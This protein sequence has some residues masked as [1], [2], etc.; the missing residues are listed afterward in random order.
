[1]PACRDDCRWELEL[2][3]VWGFVEPLLFWTSRPPLRA[4]R[5]D[6]ERRVIAAVTGSSSAG[7]WFWDAWTC[8]CGVDSDTASAVFLR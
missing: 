1:M 6:P 7:F 8:C 4:P 5:P 2:V 3:G